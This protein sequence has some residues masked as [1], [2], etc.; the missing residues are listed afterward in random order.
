MHGFKSEKLLLETSFVYLTLYL[1]CFPPN[2]VSSSHAQSNQDNSPLEVVPERRTERL[3]PI[4]RPC[5]R[6]LWVPDFR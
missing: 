3:S 5:D 6:F 4:F 2:M 1:V